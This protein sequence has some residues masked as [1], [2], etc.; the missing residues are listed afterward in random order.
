MNLVDSSGWLEYLADAPGA[1]FFAPALE[2][3][4]E[5]IVPTIC[6]LEVARNIY[7]QR[8]ED[9]ATQALELMQQSRVVQ[10]TP[11]VIG[12]AARLGKELRLPLADS[13]VY[14]TGRLYN[15]VV[16]TQDADFEGLEGVKYTPK[17]AQS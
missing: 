11:E 9:R 12:L 15:A 7:R 13:V 1:D 8:G 6:M 16:W 3:P 17:M 14:A 4:E 5:L 2:N 10:L